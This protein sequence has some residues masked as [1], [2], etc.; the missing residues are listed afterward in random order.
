[1]MMMFKGCLNVQ[2]SIC[3]QLFQGKPA[4]V[5]ASIRLGVGYFAS[6]CFRGEEEINAFV[7]AAMAVHYVGWHQV[8]RPY[9]RS[10]FFSCFPNSGGRGKFVFFDVPGR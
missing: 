5:I 4:D 7:V 8:L 1:M 9:F 2:N 3:W 6:P 10:Y